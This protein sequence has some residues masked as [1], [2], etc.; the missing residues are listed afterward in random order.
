MAQNVNEL[1]KATL[2]KRDSFVIWITDRVGTFE[3]AVLFA[4]I[5]IASITGILTGNYILG[6]AVG[7]FSSYFLQ[8]VMLPL[9]SIRQK[10]DQRHA[11]LL[12]DETHRNVMRS[13]Y[14]IEEIHKKLDQLLIK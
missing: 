11:E 9:I 8:L 3:C 5:G 13:E 6:T 1:H 2:S 7:A 4:G 14:E 12:A 10:L